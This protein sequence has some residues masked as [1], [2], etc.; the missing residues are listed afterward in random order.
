M[1]NSVPFLLIGL[2]VLG[3]GSNLPLAGTWLLARAV[4]LVLVA[5]LVAV[6]GPVLILGQF[7]MFG[8]GTIPVLTWGGLRG[9]ISVALALLL[10]E[11][12]EKSALLAAT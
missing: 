2:E 12:P 6:S 1:L 9:G 8:R 11:V 3:C 4:R 5:R 10:P 7:R